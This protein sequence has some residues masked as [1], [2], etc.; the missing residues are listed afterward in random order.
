MLRPC[1]IDEID[2]G[3]SDIA[4]RTS[5][6]GNIQEIEGALESKGI[7]LTDQVLLRDAVRQVPDHHCCG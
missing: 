3:I 4:H 6:D 2:E 7:Q 5:V 1:S